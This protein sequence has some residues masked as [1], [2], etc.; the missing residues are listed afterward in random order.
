M[1]FV[2]SIASPD[3]VS[4][5]DNDGSDISG[6]V[7]GPFNDGDELT[8]LCE[9]SGKPAP[10][11]TWFVGDDEFQGESTEEEETDGSIRIS[12]KLNVLLERKHV[13]SAVSCLLVTAEPILN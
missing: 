10:T 13:A 7:I 12:S 3:K 5:I 8:F 9:S 6:Q 4:I 11:L 2:P 1:I